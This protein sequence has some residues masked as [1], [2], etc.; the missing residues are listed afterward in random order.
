MFHLDYLN[1][2]N[3]NL[4]DKTFYELK[5][6]K[7]FFDVNP[8]EVNADI[9]LF[10]LNSSIFFNKYCFFFDIIYTYNN[11]EILKLILFYQQKVFSSIF[12]NI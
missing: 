12:Y 1:I 8:I 7:F 9:I 5:E 3:L 10:N 2:N 11:S 4:I 6:V